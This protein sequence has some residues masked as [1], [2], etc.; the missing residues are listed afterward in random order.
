MQ[1]LW[2]ALAGRYQIAADAAAAAAL[3]FI[4]LLLGR[5]TP[6]AQWKSFDVWAVL[7][8]A[9]ICLPLAFRRRAPAT[10]ML[11]GCLI[12][13]LYISLGYWPV[14]GAYPMLLAFY[15]AAAIGPLWSAPAGVAVGALV[16][17]YAGLVSPGSSMASVLAQAVAIPLVVWRV[18]HGARQLAESNARLARTAE[19]LRRGRAE[20]AR[21]VLVDERVRI[22]REL[23]DVVAHHMSV[24][25]VQA[26]LARYVLRSDPRTAGDALDAVLDTST[27]ALDEMRRMLGLLRLG[28]E[29]DDADESD[30]RRPLP[31]LEGLPDLIS[32]VESAGLPVT[33]T[34]EGRR[35]GLPH[36]VALTAYRIV[37]ESL[38][39]VLKHAGPARAAVT[40]RVAPEAVHLTVTD[41]GTG[42]P[43]PGTGHGL[44]GLRERAALYGGTLTAGPRVPHGFEVSATLPYPSSTAGHPAA[45]DDPERP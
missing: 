18:G 11:I 44:V 2:R 32:R 29:P 8:I 9:G 36:G 12:W 26:G 10:T 34:V 23:H 1:V 38:T 45:E 28:R 5:E 22:A 24:I 35:G 31:G 30:T 42:S 41:D 6:T 19:E 39:N 14:V 3:I 37:Q 40:V 16:W 17:I 4:S 27:E 7:L 43:G 21:R 20:L 15:T 25:S 13:V 33:L